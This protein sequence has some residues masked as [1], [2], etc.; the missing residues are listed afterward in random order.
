MRLRSWWTVRVFVACALVAACGDAKEEPKD[1]PT[2]PTR[3]IVGPEGGTVEY[4][5]LALEIPPGALT[6]EVEISIA[7]T[8]DS[9]SGNFVRLSPVFRF[10]PDGLEFAVPAT[11]RFPLPDG[12]RAPGIYWASAGAPFERIGGTFDGETIAGEV[13]HFSEGFVG[14]PPESKGGALRPVSSMTWPTS[15]E[16]HF[17]V[18]T[19]SA[20][21]D[22]GVVAAGQYGGEVDLGGGVTPPGSGGWMLVR[23]GPDGA[24]RWS[25]EI[26]GGST[27]F[28]TTTG[29]PDGGA[30]IASHKNIV[31]FDA[32]GGDAWRIDVKGGGEAWTASMTTDGAGRLAAVGIVNGEV[33]FGGG[34]F[35]P[36]PG[37]ASFLLVVG[38][39][40][41]LGN[42]VVHGPADEGMVSHE[43]V[44]PAPGGGFLVA[45]T[46]TQEVDLGGG[47]LPA[48]QNPR[49]SANV[50]VARFDTSGAHVWSTSIEVKD[51]KLMPASLAVDDAGRVALLA[52]YDGGKVDLGEG[53]LSEDMHG[54]IVLLSFAP[55]SGERVG[56]PTVISGA[57]AMGRPVAGAELFTSG[58]LQTPQVDFGGGLVPADPPENP[59]AGYVAVFGAERSLRFSHAWPAWID[60]GPPMRMNDLQPRAIVPGPEGGFWW[61]VMVRGEMDLGGG[62]V[63]SGG[64]G[65]SVALLRF[66]P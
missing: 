19:L 47:L 3:S 28:T 2:P 5:G 40:G 46:H 62:V 30:A 43:L 33:D 60:E 50:H 48:P 24:A 35:P 57:R 64:E 23:F 9:P 11:V 41:K 29:L 61:L 37:Q 65:Q 25:K 14:D 15:G 6:E 58:T 55:D 26:V 22:G 44:A 39:D 1:E 18:W 49:F 59:G 38:A 56:S 45:G 52:S 31:A 7:R 36:Q 17:Q 34:A 32:E 54:G 20:T 66:G 27:N 21:P 8:T 4:E 12:A 63:L 53:R 13:S 51:G 16:G 42:A 10:E